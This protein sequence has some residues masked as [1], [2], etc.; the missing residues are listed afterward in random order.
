MRPGRELIS[1]RAAVFWL[2]AFLTLSATSELCE[3]KP[4]SFTTTTHCRQ[5]QHRHRNSQ[6]KPR[7]QSSRLRSMLTMVA[8]FGVSKI[9]TPIV[10]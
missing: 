8:E 6:C 9:H 1:G 4:E 5:R 10:S 7:S 3:G 2:E